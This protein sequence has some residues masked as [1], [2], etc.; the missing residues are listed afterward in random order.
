MKAF[1]LAKIINHGKEP[2]GIA[3]YRRE[4]KGAEGNV[5]DTSVVVL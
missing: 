3:H 5:L 2:H 1:L 4:Y